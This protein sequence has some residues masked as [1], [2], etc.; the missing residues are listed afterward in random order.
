MDNIS[1][2]FLSGGRVVFSGADKKQQGKNVKNHFISLLSD[3]KGNVSSLY[4]SMDKVPTSEALKGENPPVNSAKHFVMSVA[5][6]KVS[7][8][9]KDPVVDTKVKIE[10]FHRGAGHVKVEVYEQGL[11]SIGK[12]SYIDGRDASIAITKSAHAIGESNSL[13]DVEH[14][15][16]VRAGVSGPEAI[17]AAD[18]ASGSFAVKNRRQAGKEELSLLVASSS[19]ARPQDLEKKKISLIKDADASVLVVRD[20]HTKS[21]D[22]FVHIRKFIDSASLKIQKLIVNGRA[23]K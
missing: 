16:F 10:S 7:T 2:D 21:E 23:V 15:P 5:E 18:L 3:P 20:Y 22:L 11:L 9:T 19:I 13:L 14:S 17:L 8:E 4:N 1:G 6:S 12:L